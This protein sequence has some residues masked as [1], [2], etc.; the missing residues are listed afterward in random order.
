MLDIAHASGIELLLHPPM[1]VTILSCC[2]PFYA[3]RWGERSSPLYICCFPAIHCRHLLGT[4]SCARQGTGQMCPLFEKDICSCRKNCR[5]LLAR[6]SPWGYALP[7][8]HLLLVLL[9]AFS[10]LYALWSNIFFWLCL[11]DFGSLH[12][13]NTV[14]GFC[15]HFSCAKLRQADNIGDLVP[16]V[17]VFWYRRFTLSDFSYR[18]SGTAPESVLWHDGSA[19]CVAEVWYRQSGILTATINKY[20]LFR[21]KSCTDAY[22]SIGM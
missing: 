19:A 12:L 8:G 14:S 16:L 17:A 21:Q 10:G 20:L 2:C 7:D 6:S 18:L 15:S 22:I 4:Y 5:F 11:A 1:L 3:V 9:S 13:V